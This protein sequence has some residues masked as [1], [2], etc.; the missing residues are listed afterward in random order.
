VAL[1][2]VKYAHVAE[3]TRLQQP[4]STKSGTVADDDGYIFVALVLLMT[5]NG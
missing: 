1:N 2:A 5:S 4:F 3:N